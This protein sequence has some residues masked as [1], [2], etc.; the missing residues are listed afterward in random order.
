MGGDCGVGSTKLVARAVMPLPK[1]IFNDRL[2]TGGRCGGTW[3]CSLRVRHSST[4]FS[5]TPST[6][7][8]TNEDSK[9]ECLVI[10]AIPIPV[11]SKDA[12]MAEGVEHK[13]QVAKSSQP[14]TFESLRS[15]QGALALELVQK[16]FNFNLS[17]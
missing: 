11:P 1:F 2:N 9:V 4:N 15:S 12:A 17:T 7:C 10:E 13:R 8:V 16:A 5:C 14:Y 3:N 6:N